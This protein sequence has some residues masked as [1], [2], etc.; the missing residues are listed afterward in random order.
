MRRVFADTYF[1]IAL[2]NDKDQGHAVVQEVSRS[3][4]QANLVTAQEVLSEVLAHFSG[5][6]RFVR[7]S[8]AA[9]VRG[10][11]HDPTIDVRP[12]SAQSFLDGLALYEAR[13]DKAYSLTDCVS[14]ATMRREGLTDVLTHDNHFAQEGFV[15]LL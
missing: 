5:F 1:W 12:Q 2:L 14:L 3:L 9:F 11:C 4:E 15:V 7:Q 13:P 8:A 10:I 6:G